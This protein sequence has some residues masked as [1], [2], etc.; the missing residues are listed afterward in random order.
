MRNLRLAL[1]MLFRTPFV[2]GVAVLSLALGIG[3]NT[4]IFSLFEQ[5]LLRPLPVREPE[6]LVNLGSPGPKSGSISCG[7]AGG[8][9]YVFSYPMFRDL[10]RADV[11]LE[12]AA[13]REFRVNLAFDRQ[14]RSGQ[15]M[16]VSGSYFQVLGL[17]P[18]L[19]RL[20]GPADDET[21]GGHYVAVLSH[22]YWETHL[23]ADPDVVGEPIIVNGRPFTI[24]GIAPRGFE[25]TTLGEPADIFIP[26]TMRGVV[27]P[28]FDDF[29]N[30]RSYWVYLFGRLEP[31]VT[32]ERARTAINT[33][34]G[35]IINEVEAP[36][37]VGMSERRLAQFRAKQVTVEPGSR[38]QSDIHVEARTPLLLLLTVTGIVLLIAC[39]NIANLLLARGAN[40]R[41]EMAV[42]LSLG[43]HRW[44]VLSQLLT[45]AC[46][47][48]VLG[49][50][51]GLLVAQWTLA[52]IGAILPPQAGSVLELE[53]RGRAVLFAAATSIGTGLLFGLFPALHN[54]RSELVAT[55]RAN[56]GHLTGA[57]AAARFRNTLVTAQIALAMALLASAGL[58]LRSLANLSRVELGL[59]PEN[60]VTFA[61]S[62]ELNGY[63]PARRRNL[64]QRVEEE[65]AALPGV[66]GVAAARVPLLAGSNSANDVSVEGFENG[67][68]VDSNSRYNQVG[69]GYF[70]T[71]GIPILAG[72]E[73]TAGD[74]AGT[75]KVAV[76]NEAFAKKFGLGRD[77]VGKWMALGNTTDLDIRIVGLV[78][79]ARYSGL[80]GEVPPVFFLPYR[81]DESVGRLTFYVRTVGDPGQLLRSVPSVIERLD[82]NLPVENLK[83]LPQQVR[84]NT[85]IDRLIGTLSAAFASLSTLLAAIGLYGVL[86]YTVAQRTREIGVRMALGAD[87][88]RVRALVLRQ[89]ASMFLVGGT[90]GLAAALGL[91]R[92]AR[93]LLYGLTG[94]D[95]VVMA[96]SAVLLGA[97]ALGAGYLPALRA[98]RVNPVQALK[99]E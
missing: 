64:F 11:G 74:D 44:H 6:R 89:V 57:R 51:A 3:A 38:G 10:E 9:E 22:A 94:H 67:P 88:R 71:L 72:R 47:L 33:V 20:L 16:L 60:V 2:T 59:R 13:H 92:I 69:A 97:V 68:D 66:T 32:I 91:G 18:A 48:A 43:A 65:L 40:R 73:F 4:A 39:A 21:I 41:M 27:S 52:L 90:I 7:S 53:L 55:I 23:G 79:N 46:V 14:T 24:V 15:G 19:G 84:E 29:E 87:G 70:R 62:P 17:R 34:Y 61:I 12:L 35:R 78:E 95:P 30:R 37:Q 49:G 98:S 8:C 42:R 54:T 50:A 81:Q 99:Y 83:T 85:I 26:I 28:G 58:F 31:G 25:G 5:L 36:L 82:P 86:A 93:S 56:A 63:E 96:A 45:E 80:K 77:A 76:V 75:P 1:R